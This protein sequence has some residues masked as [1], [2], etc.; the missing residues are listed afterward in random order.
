M[1]QILVKRLLL[2]V[3]LFVGL[4]VTYQFASD[5][6]AFHLGYP[7]EQQMAQVHS[8]DG[9]QVAIFSV[10]YEGRYSWW[11][12]NPKPHFYITVQHIT[13]NKVLYRETD[14]DWP[15]TKSYYSATDSFTNLAKRYAPWAEYR[16]QPE[17]VNPTSS[18]Q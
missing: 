7:S 13:N 1:K 14:F 5:W 9:G 18:L 11:P 8:P 3:L 12:A 15:I 4:T 17:S 2:A 6:L 16:F 10:K